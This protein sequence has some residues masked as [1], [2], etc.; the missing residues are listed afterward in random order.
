M[1]VNSLWSGILLASPHLLAVV[2]SL[3]PSAAHAQLVQQYFPSD[4]P[5]YAPDFSA[6]VVQREIESSRSQGVEVD[7]FVIRPSL[8]EA[9][10]YNSN[11]LGIPNSGSTELNNVASVRVNSDWTRNAV[12]AMVSVD[13]HRYLDI[14]VASYTN[15]SA[16]IGGSLRL[17]A[18]VATLAYS[19]FSLNLAATDL[20]V[21]GV[22]DPV[23]YSVNDVRIGYS[24]LRGRFSTSPSFEFEDFLF[25][26][27]SG[28]NTISYKSLSHSNE[29]GTL[30]TRYE[31]STG[32]AAIMIL[33]GI[34]AQF[35]TVRNN[36]YTDLAGFAGLDFRSDAL[37]EYRLLL[38]GETRHFLDASST[39]VTSPTAEVDAIW[40]PRRTDTV[41]AT[42]GR[43]LDD[44]ETPFA[45]NQT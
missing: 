33:R 24:A 15:W 25:G 16:S 22:V 17:G 21:F 9:F 44:P 26:A 23:P 36:N 1:K 5:G 2:A 7:S 39:S 32:N 37:I 42:F 28:A 45:R 41:T 40:T 8:T 34:G 27:P 20:G 6:S 35:N 43:R 3:F 38:G 13:D 30:T 29:I 4:I 14:P 10:G 19:H 18:D 12:G 11:T 31:L